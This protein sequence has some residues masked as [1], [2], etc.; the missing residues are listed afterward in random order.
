[1]VTL[2]AMWPTFHQFIVKMD[3]VILLENSLLRILLLEV[4]KS[5]WVNTIFAERE[6]HGEF[7]TLFLKLLRQSN[8]YTVQFV[9]YF[10]PKS[11]Y[12]PIVVT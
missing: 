5:E 12:I 11:C 2:Q 10:P 9:S 4:K 6:E 8:K 1:M 3:E 7:H